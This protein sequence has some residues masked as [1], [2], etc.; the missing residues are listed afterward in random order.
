MKRI[1]LTANDTASIA[2]KQE[3]DLIASYTAGKLTLG[4]DLLYVKA[5]Q[6]R[7]GIEGGIIF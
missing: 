7:L 1:I 3:Y 6:Y 2:N 5:N 4:S